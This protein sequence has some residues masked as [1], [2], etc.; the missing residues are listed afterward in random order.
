MSTY[1]NL[2]IYQMAFNL[3]IKI[4]RLN[5]TLSV[6]ALLNQGNK[7]RWTSLKIKDLIAEGFSG[8]KND[9]DILKILN[10]IKNLNDEVLM[11]LKKI[12]SGNAT[13]KQIPELIKNYKQL[14]YKT[15]EHIQSINSEKTD[16]IIP[17]AENVLLDIAV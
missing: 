9:K 6:N 17:F 2:E 1:K 3:A 5:V 7:L 11:L 15:E 16:Y 14:K 12:K 4:Y 13:N 10:L 8:Q